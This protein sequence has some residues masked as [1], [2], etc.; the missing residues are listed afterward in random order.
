MELITPSQIYW[1]TRLGYIQGF[2]IGCL[3]IGFLVSIITFFIMK[4]T[5]S[6]YDKA[7]HNLARFFFRIAFPAFIVG[8][9]GSFFTP[10][11]EEAMAIWGIPKIVNNQNVQSLGKNSLTVIEGGLKYVQDILTEKEKQ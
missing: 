3:A 6:E 4:I 5:V 7:E 1:M 8:L 11:T 10:S 2:F 9:F